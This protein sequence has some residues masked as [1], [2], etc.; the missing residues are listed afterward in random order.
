MNVTRSVALAAAWLVGAVACVSSS[1]SGPEEQPSRV[2]VS[3]S[4]PLGPTKSSPGGQLAVL[5]SCSKKPISLVQEGALRPVGRPEMFVTAFD[6]VDESHIVAGGSLI[7]R[8]SS[9]PVSPD[10]LFFLDVAAGGY[11]RTRLSERIRF[12]WSTCLDYDPAS[13]LILACAGPVGNDAARAG[14]ASIDMESGQVTWVVAPGDVEVTGAT[15]AGRWVLAAFQAY[16]GDGV[17]SEEWLVLLDPRTGETKELSPGRVRRSRP[18][19][20]R[21]LPGEHL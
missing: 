11:E 3:A 16:G 1:P 15:W 9:A 21:K 19:R 8:G 10:Q 20:L 13:D 4:C 18:R 17:P 6:W 14:L 5:S 12:G 2:L 7:A